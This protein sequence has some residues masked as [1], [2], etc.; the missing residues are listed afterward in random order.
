MRVA[1]EGIEG[2]RPDMRVVKKDTRVEARSPCP[3][4]TDAIEVD[5]AMPDAPQHEV[6][7]HER[8]DPHRTTAAVSEVIL[9]AQDGLVNVLGVL[10][11]V[12]AASASTRIVI[13]AG[14][15]T[16]FAESLSMAAVAYTTSVAQGEMFA[17]ERA[18][19]YRHIEHAPNLEREEVRAMYRKKGFDGEMLDRVVETITANKDVWVA[20]M[21]AEEHGRLP[22]SRREALR[23]ALIVGVSAAVGSL[24]PVV[25]YFFAPITAASWVACGVAAASLFALGAYKARVAALHAGKSGA[26]LAAI[27]IVTALVGYA[28]GAFFSVPATP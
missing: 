12:A 28:V 24:L 3:A 18:R 10:L 11:G 15:A 7:Y 5:A 13:A 26:E 17:S 9:G 8:V 21:M 16:A 4:R 14:L 25:P 1:C 19:E 6:H 20:V 23:N 27:G 22:V 2:D